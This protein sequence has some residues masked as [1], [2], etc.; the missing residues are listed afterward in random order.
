K[1]RHA[2]RCTVKLE[3]AQLV[4]YQTILIGG[5]RDPFIL[6]ELDDWL[7]HIS[8][9]VRD[10]VKKLF[11]RSLEELGARIDYHVYGR[12]GVMQTLEPNR[13]Q[14]PHEV[15][16]VVEATALDQDTATKLAQLTRQPLLHYPIDKWKG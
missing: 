13:S 6:A 12:D 5:V 15:G 10:V 2:S 8:A 3:G 7:G 16:I 9:Y 11:G 14:V 4:G 1:F